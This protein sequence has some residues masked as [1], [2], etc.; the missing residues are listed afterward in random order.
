[1]PATSQ[2]MQA[3]GFPN[4]RINAKVFRGSTTSVD[5]ERTK[6]YGLGSTTA[7]EMVGLLEKLYQG[8]LVSP[9]AS[10]EMIGHLKQCQ[11]KDMFP[12]LLPEKVAVAHKTGSVS[13]IKTDAGILYLPTGPVALCVLT[14]NNTDLPW[15]PAHPR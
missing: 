3:W 8:K 9:E 5:P 13:D 4:T 1:I 10:K 15:A 6:K 12:R 7:R 2:R 11:D 14:P